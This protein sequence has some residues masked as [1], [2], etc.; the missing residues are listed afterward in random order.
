[1]VYTVLG[2]AR[3]MLTA[4]IHVLVRLGSQQDPTGTLPILGTIVGHG[5]QWQL[6]SV[7]YDT[8]CFVSVPLS[9]CTAL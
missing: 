5:C 6:E 2:L 7:H 4:Q 9:N 8:V 3:E 1:M